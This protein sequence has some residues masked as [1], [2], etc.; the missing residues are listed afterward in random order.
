MSILA[1]KKKGY[2]FSDNFDKNT[3]DPAWELEPNQASRYTLD[4]VKGTIHLLHGT[5]SNLYLW[6]K[7]LTTEKQFVLDVRQGFIPQDVNHDAGIIVHDHQDNHLLL[8]VFQEGNVT[9]L[10]Y[11]WLRIERD[12]NTYYAYHSQDGV[13]WSVVG[14]ESF[15]DTAPLIGLYVNGAQGPGMEIEEVRVYLSRS[16]IVTGLT[17]GTK[18]ELLDKAGIPLAV[19]VCTYG[20][21]SVAFDLSLYGMEVEGAVS[22]VLPQAQQPIVEKVRTI[23]AGDV[24]T[25]QVLPDMYMTDTQGQE[26]LLDEHLQNFLGYMSTGSQTYR[27]AQIVVKNPLSGS[28]SGLK[29]QTADYKQTGQYRRLIQIAP[30]NNGVPGIYGTTVSMSGKLAAGGTYKY[31]IRLEREM[32]PNLATGEVFF[33]LDMQAVYTP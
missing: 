24:Y 23:Q 1:L 5:P 32:D 6:L 4:P 21:A 3:L 17:E 25:L 30:D 10:S 15:D 18:V 2:L 29:I 8:R 9:S 31:W 12:Y 28:F 19:R 14:A 26:H 16:V 13:Q 22:I 7:Q 27:E 20:Q 33:G 11:P